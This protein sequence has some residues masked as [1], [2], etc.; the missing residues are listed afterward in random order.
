MIIFLIYF[1]MIL[2]MHVLCT[3]DSCVAKDTFP[4]TMFETYNKGIL[5]F[6]IYT[7]IGDACV[8]VCVC[9]I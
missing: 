3:G 8:C 7:T 5:L 2:I 4:L 9:K 6:I 1:L